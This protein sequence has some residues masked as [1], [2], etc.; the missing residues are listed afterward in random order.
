VARSTPASTRLIAGSEPPPGTVDV[1]DVWET[2]KLY[3]ERPHGIRDRLFARRKTVSEDFLALKGVNLHL[4]P[5]DTVGL[6]GENG[7]GKSTLL[8]CIAGILEPSRGELQT[9][10]RVASMLEVGAGF[11]G[12]LTGRENVFLNGSILGFTRKF[13]DTVFDEII[14]FAGRQ[15]AEAIDNAVRTYSSGMY[16]RLGFA[17]SVH[18]QPDILIVDEVLAVGDAAFQKQCFDRIHELKRRGV[19]I[20]VVSHD[21]DTI[22]SLCDRGVYLQKGEVVAD[23]NAIDVVDKYREDVTA[24]QGGGEVKKWSGGEIY[25]TGDASI[26]DI[27]FVGPP[28][29]DG[30]TTGD[31]AAVEFEVEANA[32]FENP[33]FGLILRGNDG[34]Y[35]YDVN[36]MWR[37]QMTGEFAPGDVATVRVEFLVNLLPGRYVV[38][39]A[40]SRHDGRQ[41]YDWH[42]DAVGFDVVGEFTANGVVELDATITVDDRRRKQRGA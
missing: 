39:V 38:T 9:Y 34:T 22:S 28:D 36:T 16:L 40:A 13:V 23:G 37:H 30:V 10:G 3:H 26:R 11:H 17:V 1:V 20:C 14:E 33:V 6:I 35:L 18:L 31:K 8:K 21:L 29:R 12:D 27:R 42:T 2:F 32:A 24:L 7:S 5:G 19:T 15:V 4:G 25:G 41:V